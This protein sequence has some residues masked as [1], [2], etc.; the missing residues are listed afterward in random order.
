MSILS[1]AVQTHMSPVF[2]I[3]DR[4]DMHCF[5]DRWYMHTGNESSVEVIGLDVRHAMPLVEQGFE[6]VLELYPTEHSHVLFCANVIPCD[7]A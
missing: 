4:G 3:V 1:P 5:G 2:T 6:V 7:K